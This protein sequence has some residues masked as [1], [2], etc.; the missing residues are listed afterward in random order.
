MRIARCKVDD[1]DVWAVVGNHSLRVLQGAEDFGQA[2]A[3]ACGTDESRTQSI[4][5]AIPL[6]FMH[7][8]APVLASTKIICAGVNYAKH[9]AE[10]ARQGLQYP[11]M[12]VRFA[13][14]FV[15]HGEPVIRPRVTDSFDY[16]AELVVVI[17]RAGR[18]IPE[19]LAL[20]YVG[21]YTCMAENSARDYQK[22]NAQV[23]PGK[24]FDRSGS[25]GPWIVTPQTIPDPEALVVMGRLNGGIVQQAVVR[26]LICPVARLIAYV[27]TF[28]TLR[29]WRH[30]R[31]RHTRGCRC[32]EKAATFHA[33]G[34]CFRSG[35]QRSW[36][37]A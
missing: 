14:S 17:G 12:F 25:L 11:S 28:M 7:W 10:M 36:V 23:T 6:E 13:D 5:D 27:S 4:G 26:E 1:A 8:L 33:G 18:H 30:D 19:D 16:E 35:H 32:I 9:A 15:G 2:I 34:R 21:G 31:N 29:P 37:P 24:N 20:E 3:C 22:H